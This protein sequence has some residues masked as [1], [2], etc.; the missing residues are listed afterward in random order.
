MTPSPEDE[1][2]VKANMPPLTNVTRTSMLSRTPS[3]RLFE[4]EVQARKHAKHNVLY[5]S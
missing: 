4:E 3:E 5:L 2:A 1:A